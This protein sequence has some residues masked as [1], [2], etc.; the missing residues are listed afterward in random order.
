MERWT[1]E[2]GNYYPE[3]ATLAEVRYRGMSIEVMARAGSIEL[4]TLGGRAD[5][6]CAPRGLQ[7]FEPSRFP[8]P[9]FVL[10][11]TFPVDV[12][13]AATWITAHKVA[14]FEADQGRPVADI[15][16]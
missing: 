14:V 1:H 4:N 3:G 5:N 6:P 8:A 2:P 7:R 9:V 11:G 15:L 16:Y 10:S 12:E 13:R